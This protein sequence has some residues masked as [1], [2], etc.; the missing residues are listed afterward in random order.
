LGAGEYDGGAAELL[1]GL[2]GL[3]PPGDASGG[4]GGA[5]AGGRRRC[6]NAQD[7]D[8][9]GGG[10]GGEQEGTVRLV[11]GTAYH[12]RHLGKLAPHRS[13]RGGHVEGFSTKVHALAFV[14]SFEQALL[15]DADNLAVQVWHC[16]A[17]RGGGVVFGG[18]SPGASVWARGCKAA[19]SAP[20]EPECTRWA[21]VRRQYIQRC[22]PLVGVARAHL[23]PFP[24]ARSS[25]VQDPTPLFSHPAFLEHGNLFWPDFWHSM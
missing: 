7:S 10:G 23:V 19:S 20:R 6:D 13:G 5:H 24:R 1:L 17:A 2:D 8:G 3:A 12:R 11:D 4:A 22:R 15:L 9:G 16:E 14:T 25:P 21:P 18:C